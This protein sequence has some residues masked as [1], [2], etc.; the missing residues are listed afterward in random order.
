M[1]RF[2]ASD[3][4]QPQLF[5]NEGTIFVTD[6]SAPSQKDMFSLITLCGGQ[7]HNVY[8]PSIFIFVS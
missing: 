5:A 8:I 3:V 1:L 6:K 4:Y 2:G 7:V